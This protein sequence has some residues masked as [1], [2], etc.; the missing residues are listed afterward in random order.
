MDSTCHRKGEQPARKFSLDINAPFTSFQFH[1]V[2]LIR[3]YLMTPNAGNIRGT[4]IILDKYIHKSTKSIVHRGKLELCGRANRCI[5]GE[6]WREM[7]HSVLYG[8]RLNG[9]HY[10]NAMKSM[11]TDKPANV[12]ARE[13]RRNVTTPNGRPLYT[14]FTFK[15]CKRWP[16]R[17]AGMLCAKSSLISLCTSWYL[18]VPLG[19]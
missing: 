16:M 6:A 8:Y 17:S 5:E 12:S 1:D 15:H 3:R 19:H 10:S 2:F 13:H 11:F 14:G 7:C 9:I 18:L 4:Y